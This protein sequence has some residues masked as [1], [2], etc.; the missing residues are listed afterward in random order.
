VEL[1]EYLTTQQDVM[2]TLSQRITYMLFVFLFGVG[3]SVVLLMCA[4]IGGVCRMF[5]KMLHF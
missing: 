5:T 3:F 2:N 1:D 4:N